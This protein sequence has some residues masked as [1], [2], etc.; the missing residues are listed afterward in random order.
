MADV[1]EINDINELSSYQLAWNSMLSETP[2]ASFLHTLD[3]LQ[4][5][6]R[7]FG[8]GQKLRALV[9]R[10]QGSP[11]SIVPLCVRTERRRYGDVRVLTYPLDNWGLWYGPIGRCQA[12]ALTMAMRHIA[13]TPRD[14]DQFEPRWMAHD[15]TD[16][17]RTERAMRGAGLPAETTPYQA[18]SVIDMTQFDGWES[19]LQSRTSKT[20]HELRRIPRRLAKI[21]EVE[22]T[23]HRPEPFAHGDGDPAWSLY[24]ECERVSAASWQASKNAGNTLADER[25]RGFYRDTH[26]AAARLGMVDMNV[27]RID[28]EPLAYLYNYSCQGRVF[29]LRMG[30]RQDAPSGVGI[31]LMAAALQ[32]SFARGDVA[33]DLGIGGEAFKR[34]M[35]THVET[36]YRITHTPLTGWKPQLLRAARWWRGRRQIAT[37]SA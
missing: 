29:G 25:Y 27:L 19:Y 5:Y 17:G 3:W 32:E 24:N 8:E 28:G 16:R 9:V 13:R 18:S 35:R 11:I 1:L 34:R 6:W 26:A 15:T 37:K 33:Y 4:T 30:Y 12:A 2:R 20:R 10:S 14:W 7:H 21:G 31:G 36:N 22:V 23:H